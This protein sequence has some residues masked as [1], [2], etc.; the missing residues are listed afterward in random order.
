MTIEHK[1]TN[2][3]ISIVKKILIR[4]RKKNSR[5]KILDF[6]DLFAL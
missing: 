1:S 3:N 5:I 6:Y 2:N 4:K